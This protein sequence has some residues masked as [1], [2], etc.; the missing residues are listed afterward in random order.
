MPL[1]KRKHIPIGRPCEALQGLGKQKNLNVVSDVLTVLRH[2][3]RHLT[4]F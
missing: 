3:L 4:V 2:H 1:V